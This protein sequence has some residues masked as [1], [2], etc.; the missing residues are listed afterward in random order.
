MD[1]MSEEFMSEELQKTIGISAF[2]RKIKR[3][4]TEV[5]AKSQGEFAELINAYI[6]TRNQSGEVVLFTRN[7]VAKLENNNGIKAEKLFF[8][9]NFLFD[10]KNIN[11]AWLMLEQNDS[12]PP[13]LRKIPRD[14]NSHLTL[15]DI[16]ENQPKTD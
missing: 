2:G 8:L 13:Y 15:S 9:I 6:K 4:R 10:S 14:R 7:S 11:P 12:H 5:F 16:R 3:I 1:S